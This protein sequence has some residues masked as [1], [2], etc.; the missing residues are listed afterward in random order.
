[1]RL[2]TTDKQTKGTCIH[3]LL[4]FQRTVVTAIEKKI[5]ERLERLALSSENLTQNFRN[6]V[7]FKDESLPRL[8][9][10]VVRGPQWKWGNQDSGGPGTVINHTEGDDEDKSEVYICHNVYNEM[11]SILMLT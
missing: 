5:D 10:R 7:E 3:T 2:S 11:N 4:F 9:S 1:M 6:V 8:G